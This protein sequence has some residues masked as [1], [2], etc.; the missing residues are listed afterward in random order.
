MIIN[1][2]PKKSHP[3]KK[4]I[5]EALKKVSIKNST[6]FIGFV[7]SSISIADTNKIVK[8]KKASIVYKYVCQTGYNLTKKKRITLYTIKKLYNLCQQM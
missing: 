2:S 8:K 1:I 6:A 4:K 5:L 7:Q 3:T